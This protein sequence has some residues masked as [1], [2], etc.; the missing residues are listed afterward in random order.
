M[1]SILWAIG[2]EH[3]TL[4]ELV[5]YCTSHVRAMLTEHGIMVHVRVEEVWPGYEV[6]AELRRNTFLIIKEAA[7]NVV[8]HAHAG[9]V[10]I[11][12]RYDAGLYFSVRDDGKWTPTV[13]TEG[14]GL[15]TMRDRACDGGRSQR[16]TTLGW[17]NRT[18]APGSNGYFHRLIPMYHPLVGTRGSAIIGLPN[19]K[20]SIMANGWNATIRCGQS[21]FLIDV[22]RPARVVFSDF[23]IVFNPASGLYEVELLYISDSTQQSPGSDLL[24]SGVRVPGTVEFGLEVYLDGG[25]VYNE[26]PVRRTCP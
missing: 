11:E 25:L 7:N 21:T 13:G 3:T 8:K 15:R 10:W 6:G 20:S 2:P 26:V 9:N 19:Q 12:A 18:A 5:S 22:T 16:R 23:I 14:R 17:R 4:A 24:D 1:R